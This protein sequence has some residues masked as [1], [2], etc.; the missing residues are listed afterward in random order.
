MDEK[1]KKSVEYILDFYSITLDRDS[2]LNDILKVVNDAYS[3]GWSDAKDDSLEEDYLKD[4]GNWSE[5]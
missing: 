2:I 5:D 3:Q 4:D 1:F